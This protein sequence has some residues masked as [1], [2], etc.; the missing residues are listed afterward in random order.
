MNLTERRGSS[1]WNEDILNHQQIKTR[2]HYSERF[3]VSKQELQSQ[4]YTNPS[5]FTNTSFRQYE[6]FFYG[7]PNRIS[8]QKYNVSN[9]GHVK[10]PESPSVDYSGTTS[11]SS[12]FGHSRMANTQ[13]SRA[14]L[15]S[16]SEPKQRPSKKK[17]MRSPSFGGIIATPDNR[18]QDQSSN[19]KKKQPPWSIKRYKAAKSS[20]D[21][22]YDS[23]RIGTSS[24]SS[25]RSLR[26]M[27]V[28]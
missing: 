23:N 6:E 21:I 22:E 8:Q 13:S 25:Y 9:F 24:S 4:V 17:T 26:H 1:R 27:L 11:H 10:A 14:N 5:P 3:S 7:T 2:E 20:K 19:G 16:S 28:K 18:G 15:R 12:Q